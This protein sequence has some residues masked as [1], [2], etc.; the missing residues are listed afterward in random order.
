[1]AMYDGRPDRYGVMVMGGR[2]EKRRMDPVV[3]SHSTHRAQYTCRVCHI[4]L[5]FSMKKGG[6]ILPGRITLMAVFAGPAMM[7]KLLFQLNLPVIA[8]T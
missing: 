8:A 1:M 3:F 6:V 2:S 4:D 7:E 5:E